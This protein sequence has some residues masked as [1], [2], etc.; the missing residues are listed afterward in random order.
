MSETP[1][2]G[3]D[4]ALA[5]GCRCA[6]LDNNHGKWPPRPPH[7]FVTLGCPVHAPGSPPE[8]EVP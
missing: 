4:E 5:L 8:G 2:P 6:V 7:W 3:S 1:N